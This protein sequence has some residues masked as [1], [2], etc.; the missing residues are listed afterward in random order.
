MNKLFVDFHVI[1]TVPPSCV[2]RDD[3]GS[4]KT[5]VYGG[6]KRARVSSQSWKH[7]MRDMFREYFDESELGMRTVKVV[8][9]LA[10]AI[11]LQDNSKN[12]E[13]ALTLARD[14]VKAM[15]LKTEK[16]DD[17]QAL[18]F[19]GT[20]QCKNLAALALS[21]DLDKKSLK[22]VLGEG[23]AVDIALFGRMV[24]ADPG[25]NCDASS[26]VAHAISTHAVTSEFDYFT[27]L[28]DLKAE[29]TAGA[30]MIGTVEFNSSTLY[31]YATIATHEL[32]YQL[33]SDTTATAKAVGEFARAF[34]LSMPTGKQNTF[35]NYTPPNALLVTLREDTSVNLVGAFEKPIRPTN[36][37]GYVDASIARLVSHA[38]AMYQ[39]FVGVPTKTYV[40]GKGLEDVSEPMS[41][42]A[43]LEDLQKEVASRCQ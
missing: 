3:T 1:Q 39:S 36:G 19:L 10:H 30:T 21:G 2:N 8:Q 35:A 26:Q 43:M 33:G 13:E 7:A 37:E 34:T 12:E 11:C 23:H 14:I 42:Q 4:P 24:A 29:D 6:A 9:M 18:F 16:N 25:L 22:K 5:A 38:N 40:V 15:D 41:M 32:F 28:D 27:A 31:R 20:Q 17:L